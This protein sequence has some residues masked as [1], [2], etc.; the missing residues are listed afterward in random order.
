MDSATIAL[1]PPSVARV[2]VEIDLLNP[3]PKRVWVGVGTNDAEDV[4][5]PLEPGN[6]P[7]YCSFCFGRGTLKLIIEFE[8][9][10]YGIGLISNEIK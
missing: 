2:C 4:W 5:Q 1:S 3:L 9:Q 7:L 6:L 10:S 8:I